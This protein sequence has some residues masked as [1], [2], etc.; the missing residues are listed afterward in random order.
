MEQ[1]RTRKRAPE[2][3][4]L[5]IDT[6][7]L[8]D[9]YRLQGESALRTLKALERHK[10]SLIVGDQLRMEFMNNRQRAILAGIEKLAKPQRPA[11]PAILLDSKAAKTWMK[12]HETAEQRWKT[13]RSRIEAI[14]SDP[15]KADP[16]YQSLT[17]IFD[18]DGPYNLCRPD[19]KRFA[20]RNLARKRFSLGYPPR[21]P[22]ASTLGDSIHWEWI[23]ACARPNDRERHDVMIVS[24]DG[25]FGANLGNKATI[26]DWLAREFRERVSPQRQIIL[27]TRLTDALKKL[28]EQVSAADV[29]A[30]DEIIKDEAAERLSD[31]LNP[32]SPSSAEL[33]RHVKEYRELQEW[34]KKQTKGDE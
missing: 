8:L 25:D 1:K 13:A 15:I 3:W 12:A 22:N 2:S 24:R 33:V 23:I 29:A 34:A 4:L 18:H 9:F 28:D 20:I 21:K 30:E 26:N 5:F 27:F 16:V 31:T 7:I 11:V 10:D 32:N 19:K 6:N 14:L 17:R